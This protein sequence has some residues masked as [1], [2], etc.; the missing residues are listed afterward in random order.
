[1]Y[2]MTATF[3]EEFAKQLQEHEIFGSR[4]HFLNQSM[5]SLFSLT[6]PFWKYD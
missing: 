5:Q 2:P 1:M 4:N 3:T 6:L